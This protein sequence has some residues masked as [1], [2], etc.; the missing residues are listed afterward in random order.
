MHA[1]L[2][3]SKR[4]EDKDQDIKKNSENDERQVDE[5]DTRKT[6][7]KSHHQQSANEEDNDEPLP[8]KE[9]LGS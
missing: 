3:S 2:F 1:S 8:I 9:N 6:K 7:R 5:L 4:K